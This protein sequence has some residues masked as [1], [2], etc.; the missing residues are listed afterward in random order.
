MKRHFWS[1]LFYLVTCCILAFANVGSVVAADTS[2]T[3]DSPTQPNELDDGAL[4]VGVYYVNDYE[5]CAPWGLGDR[6]F[7]S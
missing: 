7:L 2:N 4:E 1:K 5:N 3:P 6:S